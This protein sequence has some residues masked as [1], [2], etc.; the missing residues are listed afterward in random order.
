MRGKSHE[1]RIRDFV[2][3]SNPY[4]KQQHLELLVAENEGLIRYIAR[5]NCGYLDS[6]ML[7]EAYYGFLTAIISYD[8]ER[9]DRLVPWAVM[10]IRS[11][12]QKAVRAEKKV[13]PANITFLAYH[14]FHDDDSSETQQVVCPAPTPEEVATK[15]ELRRLVEQVISTL[16]SLDQRIWRLRIEEGLTLREIANQEGRSI[17][18]IRNRLYRIRQTLRANP[19]IRELTGM[20]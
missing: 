10:C 4:K 5:R 17:N 3:E 8:P 7:Q 6:D 20:D 13:K 9:C 2:R 18:A 15:A 19:Q 16:S 11:A 14:I 1:A 12:I